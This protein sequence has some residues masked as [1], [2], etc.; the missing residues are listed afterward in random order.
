MKNDTL[1]AISTLC[2]ALV[3]GEEVNMDMVTEIQAEVDGEISR[4]LEKK[5]ANQTLYNEAHEIFKTIIDNATKPLT[6]AEIFNASTEWPD[7]FTE[8]K[9]GYGLRSAWANEVDKIQNG[10]EPMTYKKKE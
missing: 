6:R 10:R 5:Q 3:A 8:G 9:L 1:N 7:T 4:N 2:N